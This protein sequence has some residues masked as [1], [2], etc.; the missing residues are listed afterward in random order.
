MRLLIGLIKLALLPWRLV[1]AVVVVWLL[2]M[3]RC[4]DL[5]MRGGARGIRFLTWCWPLVVIGVVIALALAVPV[6]LARSS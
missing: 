4:R 2:W 1:G 5:E 6:A 3:L